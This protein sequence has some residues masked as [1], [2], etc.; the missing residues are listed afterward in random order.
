MDRF[1]SKV[2]LRTLPFTYKTV[3]G[4]VSMQVRYSPGC[5]RRAASLA[6]F[7]RELSVAGEVPVDSFE[8]LVLKRSDWQARLHAPYGLP[9]ARVRETRVIAA[10]D[11]PERLVNGLDEILLDAAERGFEAPS[12][13]RELFDVLIGV[14]WAQVVTPVELRAGVFW[15]DTLVA[16]G[17]LW[18]ACVVGDVLD[19]ERLRQWWQVCAAGQRGWVARAPHRPFERIRACGHWGLVAMCLFNKGDWP[20]F[21]EIVRTL[22][23]E[24]GKVDSAHAKKRLE[25]WL[26]PPVL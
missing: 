3:S 24:R 17:Q 8:L 5:K 10:A 15:L 21:V 1:A 18:R 25:H 19:P 11:Y 9:L 2:Y 16:Q 22:P 14:C 23:R 26:E 12:G 6:Q 13:W 20:K 7:L 4:A